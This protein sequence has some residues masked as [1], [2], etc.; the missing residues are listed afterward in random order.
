[1]TPA[2]IFS[3]GPINSVVLSQD[4]D[5]NFTTSYQDTFSD[6]SFLGEGDVLIEVGW[7]SLNYKD[8]MALKGDKGVV[9]TVPLIP[10]IDVVGTVIE[11]ADPRFGRGDEVVLNGAGLGRTGMEVSRSG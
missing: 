6:P 1:M 2:H 7:S 5:G 4:E 10:G 11:S 3:E 8:A 9:R